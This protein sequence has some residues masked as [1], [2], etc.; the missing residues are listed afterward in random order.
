MYSK[1]KRVVLVECNTKWSTSGTIKL[2]I[3]V[4]VYVHLRQFSRRLTVIAARKNNRLTG[5]HVG[6][7]KSQRYSRF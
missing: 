5:R 4:V 2:I 7:L 6:G 3:L 1:L